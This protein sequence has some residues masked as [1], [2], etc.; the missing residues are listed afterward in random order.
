MAER[1][2][3]RSIV[4]RSEK[5]SPTRPSFFSAWKTRPSKE[6]MPGRLLAAVLEGVQ[7]DA[8]DGGGVRVAEDAEDAAFLAQ[9]SPSRSSPPR[10]RPASTA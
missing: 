10:I 1:P 8:G 3:R 6:T 2:R 5:E 9:V 4:A 7:A